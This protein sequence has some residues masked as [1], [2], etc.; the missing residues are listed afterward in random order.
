MVADENILSLALDTGAANSPLLGTLKGQEGGSQQ[1]SC[2]VTAALRSTPSIT[3]TS[4]VLGVHAAAHALKQQVIAR[5]NCTGVTAKFC[6]ITNTGRDYSTGF[7]ASLLG[8]TQKLARYIRTMAEEVLRYTPLGSLTE[9]SSFVTLSAYPI[10]RTQ[11][12][13]S[14][15]LTTPKAM[16]PAIYGSPQGAKTPETNGKST[17]CSRN[18]M[19]YDIA[20]AGPNNRFMIATDAGALIVHNCGYGMGAAKFKVQL[21]NFGVEVEFDECRRIIDTYR[22]TYPAIPKLWNSANNALNAILRNQSTTLGSGD[23]LSVE[24]ANG[25]MLPNGLRLKY[26]NLR[27]RQDEQTGKTELIYDTKK[28]KALIPTRIYG[29][30]MVENVCQA[31]A[32]I[33][34]GG[35][36]LSVAKKYRVVLTVHDAIACIVPKEEADTAKE[37]IELCMRLRPSWALDLPLNCEAGYGESYRD[38]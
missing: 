7:L 3:T 18:L 12:E 11:A 35:Q 31:L 2:G 23:I 37:Y 16:N 9:R 25:V 34:I 30:K 6:R 38:C 8:A 21:K 1:S 15:V 10:G 19:T 24:G 17:S 5:A 14:T 29:G 28:G 22:S 33:I 20:Y 13:T 32:R 36:M 27:L 26:P 4:K